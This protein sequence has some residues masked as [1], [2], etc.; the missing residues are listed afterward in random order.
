MAT[1]FS[2]PDGTQTTDWVTARDAYNSSKGVQAGASGSAGYGGSGSAAGGGG[3]QMNLNAYEPQLAGANNPYYKD[4]SSLMS[5]PGAAMQNNPVFKWQQ[6]QGEQAVNRAAA[7]NGQLTSGNRG[8]ALSDYAQKQSGNNFFTLADLYS[9]LGGQKQGDIG[10][11]ATT[12]LN[13][14]RINQGDYQ[15]NNNFNYNRNLNDLTE[16]GLQAGYGNRGGNSA[17]FGSGP[18]F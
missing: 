9:K 7:A 15:Y 13:Q 4:L 16:Q 11:A 5:N 2:M 17:S 10:A 12:N 3:G 14:Q 8:M 6:Q 1:F 18:A